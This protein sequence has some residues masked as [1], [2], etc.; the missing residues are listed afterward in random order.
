MTT[1][2]RGPLYAPPSEVADFAANL[3][4]SFLLCR[5]I[6]HNW[7]PFGAQYMADGYYERVLRCTRCK[8]ER[9]ETIT[10]RGSK[11]GTH[12]K[13]PDGYQHK[14]LGRIVGD[15]KDALRLESILRA[16]GERA[17]IEE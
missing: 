2:E 4:I 12:Y 8:T 14:G 3:T 13:Y 7:R 9:W 16:V 11:N 5:D 1:R 15:G 6:G 10:T 17:E